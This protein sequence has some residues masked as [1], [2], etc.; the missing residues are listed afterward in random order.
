MADSV[1]SYTSCFCFVTLGDLTLGLPDQLVMIDR[2]A[3]DASL[4]GIQSGAYELGG[5]LWHP[6]HS[7]AL[8]ADA[9]LSQPA[10]LIVDPWAEE[11]L[12]DTKEAN[13][14]AGLPPRQLRF[15]R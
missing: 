8:V 10:V 3:D 1:E 14:S 7:H 13:P 15:F 12:V 5:V 6:I 9:N 11:K 4:L 2:A